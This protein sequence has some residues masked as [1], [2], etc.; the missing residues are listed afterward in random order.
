MIVD[1]EV[2]QELAEHHPQRPGA[3]GDRRLDELFL[4][5]R[6]HLAADRPRHV[7]DRRRRR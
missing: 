5:Q 1:G 7:G 2:G 4:A 3:L 6:Q